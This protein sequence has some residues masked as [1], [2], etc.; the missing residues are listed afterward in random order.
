MAPETLHLT[1]YP[2]SATDRTD[3]TLPCTLAQGR[4]LISVNW[5]RNNVN[6]FDTSSDADISAAT[7]SPLTTSPEYQS[8]SGRISVSSSIQQHNVTLRTNFKLDQGSVW[9]CQT[10]IQFSNDISIEVKE[11]IQVSISVYAT[12]NP[13]TDEQILKLTCEGTDDITETVWSKNLVN[14]FQTTLP[15]SMLVYDTDSPEYKS[16]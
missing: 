5:Y 10:G 15:R 14:I 13:G 11:S 8:V 4:A 3:F 1:S 7:L 2:E 16:V 9:A 6:I 12:K